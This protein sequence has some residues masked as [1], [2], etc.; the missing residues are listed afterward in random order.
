MSRL[1]MGNRT[2]RE[3]AQGFL[4]AAVLWVAWLAFLLWTAG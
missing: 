2:S 3:A 1:R 4:V